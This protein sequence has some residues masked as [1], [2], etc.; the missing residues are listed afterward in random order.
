MA[1]ESVGISVNCAPIEEVMLVLDLEDTDA[2]VVCVASA[3]TR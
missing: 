3:K 2:D 1:R